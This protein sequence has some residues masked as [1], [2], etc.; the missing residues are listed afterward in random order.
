MDNHSVQFR[1]IYEDPHLIDLS[2]LVVH[3]EWSAESTA[4]VSQSFLAESGRS[5]LGWVEAPTEP[6]VIEAGADTGVGW[7]VLQFYTI[8]LARHARCAITLATRNSSRESRPA[9]TSRFQIELPTEIGLIQRFGRECIAL[10]N[11]FKL[12]ARLIGTAT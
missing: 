1:V 11:N 4:Y 6:L 8:D 12:D 10:G 5:I 3:G 9:K 7:I 2:V